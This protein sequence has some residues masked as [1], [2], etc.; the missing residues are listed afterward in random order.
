MFK[1]MGLQKKR[2]I[3]LIGF[4]FIFLGG[5]FLAFRLL[6]FHEDAAMA[7][8]YYGNSND[9]IVTVD[10]SRQTIERHYDQ[11][12]PSSYDGDYPIIDLDQQTITLLGDYTVNGIRQIVVIKYDFNKRSVQIIEEQSP[13]NICSREGES[14]GWPLICLPNRIRVEFVTDQGD[15]TV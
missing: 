15:F 13:N 12:V 3:Y 14:T 10:F 11:S 9:P 4:L 6:A 1:K 2:D 5:V 7:H 8:I